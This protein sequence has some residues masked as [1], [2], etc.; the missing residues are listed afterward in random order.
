[1]YV[2]VCSLTLVFK[3]KSVCSAKT[4]ARPEPKIESK[5]GSVCTD[6]GDSPTAPISKS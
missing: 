4:K 2:G 1:M 3:V 5:A 6:R